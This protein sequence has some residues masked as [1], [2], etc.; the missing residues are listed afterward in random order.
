VPLVGEFF[1]SFDDA[2]AY[3]LARAEPLES[4]WD[5]L[6]DD[7]AATVRGWLIVPPEEVKLKARELQDSFRELDWIAPVPD[8]FLHLWLGATQELDV[9]AAARAWA[10]V[11]PFSIVY[12]RANCFH[13]A[14]IV[15]AHTQG[16]PALV[17]RGFPAAD[18]VLLLP[19]MSIGYMRRAE[20]ADR[21]R[22][23]LRPFRE[24]ELGTG[25]A[26]EVLLCDIPVAKS[27]FLQRWRIVGSVKLQG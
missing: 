18:L 24:V 14:A 1:T 5:E 11:A 9:D 25:V 22:A 27:T 10:D 2:W 23:A 7:R 21:L 13:D 15:E 19:H 17:E 8:H 20:A 3:F 26:A 4:F 16:V 12:R 6:S